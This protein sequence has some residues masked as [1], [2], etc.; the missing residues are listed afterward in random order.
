[1][2]SVKELLNQAW[3][4]YRRRVWALLGIAFLGIVLIFG[5]AAAVMGIG[6]LLGI[7]LPDL[8]EILLVICGVLS[9]FATFYMA[10]RGN[11]AFF[12]AV[13]QEHLGVKEAYKA[14]KSHTFSHLWLA[15]LTG[16]ILSG[17]YL[18]FFIPGLVFQVW[19][20]FSPFVL[21]S[22]NLKGMTAMLRSRDLV[23][24]RWWSVVWRLLAGWGTAT[25]VS[26]IPPLF[27][28]TPSFA[29]VYTF[30]V[31]KD[32]LRMR[33]D[34]PFS[35]DT[36]AKVKLM[37]VPVC[38]F[39]LAPIFMIGLTGAALLS[40]IFGMKKGLEPANMEGQVAYE[41]AQLSS[42]LNAEFDKNVKLP[43]QP[44]GLVWNNGEFLA[45]NQ[46]EP[47]GFIRIKPGGFLGKRV[48]KV[49]IKN[50]TGTNL[51]PVRTVA[52]NGKN[53]ISIASRNYVEGGGEE[54]EDV[55]VLHD[56]KTLKPLK[57]HPAPPFL[58]CLAWDGT[59]YWAA[60][61]QNTQDSGEGA[62]IFR[63]DKNF[64]VTARMA[65]P[66]VGCQ[67][68]VWAAGHLWL[69]DVFSSQ[70]YVLFMQPGAPWVMRTY[71]MKLNY[72]SGIAFDGEHIWVS[73]YGEKKLWR[74][75]KEAGGIVKREILP[76]VK[77][78][79]KGKQAQDIKAHKSVSHP[80]TALQRIIKKLELKE[81]AT[82]YAHIPG[83]WW[84]GTFQG[85]PFAARPHPGQNVLFFHV[86]KLHEITIMYLT[87]LER[88][89]DIIPIDPSR[90]LGQYAPL[91]CQ[92]VARYYVLNATGPTDWPL[93]RNPAVCAGLPKLSNKVKEVAFYPE[94]M[95]L[96]MEGEQT[97]TEDILK[98][99]SIAV[100]IVRGL[101]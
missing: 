23:R 90:R 32:L 59:G 72:L 1:M 50:L 56:A 88:A 93:L 94:G 84:S 62:Y 36:E 30:V 77:V 8:K 91:E 13:A 40:A 71:H 37:A 10:L 48:K 63:L 98:D 14:G 35:P 22:E 70:I 78:K 41:L 81:T 39:V 42:V 26:A 16:F 51:M 79:A 6:F 96:S 38:G 52:W 76:E 82:G 60:T 53:Y 5:P 68:A 57:T 29:A 73:E 95:E 64:K 85:L 83:T 34:A 54:N 100:E 87:H 75:K 28:F 21:A 89:E 15:M 33:G 44:I 7:I 19:F 97:A 12:M 9:L 58:G 31:Y 46:V 65:S 43:G 47:W 3:E 99:V 80:S 67:G 27:L 18:L 101:R 11:A 55:F 17:S 69:A 49:P 45:G 66:G 92:D 4:I 74:M 20:A 2:K 61:R 24:G 86:G 25:I